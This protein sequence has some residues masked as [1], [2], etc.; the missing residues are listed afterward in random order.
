MTTGSLPPSLVLLTAGY[1]PE[2]TRRCP[3]INN[4][5]RGV[6]RLTC[7]LVALHKRFGDEHI[8]W[9]RPC[10]CLSEVGPRGHGNK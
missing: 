2:R 8:Q 9:S 1:F 5:H 6:Q 10:Q 4:T 7:V 3:G